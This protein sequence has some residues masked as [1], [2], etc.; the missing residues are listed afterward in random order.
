MANKYVVKEE[1]DIWTGGTKTVI[2]KDT[3]AEDVGAG[4]GIALGLLVGA[5]RSIKQSNGERVMQSAIQAADNGNDQEA[6]KQAERLVQMFPKEANAHATRG[7]AHMAAQRFSDAIRDFSKAAEL[8]PAQAEIFL[9]RGRSFLDSNQLANAIRDFTR[10]TQLQPD[11]DYGY[12]WLG[13]ALARIEDYDLAL[14]N[15]N[16]AVEL[17]PGDEINRKMRGQIYASM[18]DYQHAIADFSRVVALKPSAEHYRLRA[19]A[20]RLNGDE[21]KSAADI[22]QAT[23]IEEELAQKQA[24]EIAARG[25][26][27]A[28][29]LQG[30]PQG[31]HETWICS[32]CQ[33][34]V[35][36]DATFCKHCHRQF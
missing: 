6:M 12:Y 29:I 33:G 17:N 30:P 19:E 23:H 22:E 28:S 25:P 16:R 21:T 9:C 14:T 20:Y 24:A 5:S 35:R 3:T 34:F 15:L 31:R 36:K 26:T 4:I 8:D 13:I 27:R 10:I 11:Q 2:K 7:Y 18:N 32:V 1:A